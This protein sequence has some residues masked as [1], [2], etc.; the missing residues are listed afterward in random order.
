MATPAMPGKNYEPGGLAFM[1]DGTAQDD[2]Q[3]GVPLTESS[4]GFRSGGTLLTEV[5]ADT[6]VSRGDLLLITRVR[7]HAPRNKLDNYPEAPAN[8]EQWNIKE[9][10]HYD[11][12]V[13]IVAG[14]AVI[15]AVFGATARVGQFRGTMRA[16]KDRHAW[17]DRAYVATYSPAALFRNPDIKGL[18]AADITE[19]HRLMEDLWKYRSR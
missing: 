18:I 14:S 4:T 2:Q 5:L 15:K 3:T 16:P 19:A 11:P 7:C 6:P 17:G 13:V 12:S 10:E 1:V 9:L 8:C